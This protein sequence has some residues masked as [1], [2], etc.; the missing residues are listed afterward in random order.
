VRPRQS[1][2]TSHQ[3][4][5]G[6]IGR[7][8]RD[9]PG[10]R[11]AR[12]ALAAA[13]RNGVIHPTDVVSVL[14]AVRPAH[15]SVTRRRTRVPLSLG[16][17]ARSLSH[18]ER[19]GATA[20]RQWT[21]LTAHR[22]PPCHPPWLPCDGQPQA[23]PV[24]TQAIRANR[25]PSRATRTI[26]HRC[27]AGA[28]ARPTDIARSK[29]EP[30]FAARRAAST[31]PWAGEGFPFRRSEWGEPDRRGAAQASG[32][33]DRDRILRGVRARQSS[34][35]AVRPTTTRIL[36]RRPAVASSRLRIEPR[37]S[38]PHNAVDRELAS[39]SSHDPLLRS[40]TRGRQRAIDTA[41][42]WPL[43]RAC[44]RRAAHELRRIS[45]PEAR[46]WQFPQ[47]T[48]ADAPFGAGDT[49]PRALHFSHG[50]SPAQAVG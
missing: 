30:A 18:A 50:R 19:I 11:S 49:P 23:E 25:P 27:G 15:P 14:A 41:P 3:A 24:A 37:H 32:S 31:A 22:E 48:A 26:V 2:G 40:A 17:A 45:A 46:A 44:G 34:M 43:G 4:V 42:S 16:R 5:A 35:V 38:A 29:A 10:R 8:G 28:V 33:R 7:R 1:R 39:S 9:R 20:R 12:R 36:D 13:K 21:R 6:P 47:A